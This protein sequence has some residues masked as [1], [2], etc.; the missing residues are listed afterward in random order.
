MAMRFSCF[1]HRQIYCPVQ[2][3]AVRK[4]SKP[5]CVSLTAHVG[6]GGVETRVQMP[7]ERR[8]G[9][10]NPPLYN[11][12]YI[13]SLSS[14]YGE[15]RH[16]ERASELVKQVK[17]A[18]NEEI[19]TV[20]KLELIDDLQRLGVSYLMEDEI[21]RI[22]DRLYAERFCKDEEKRSLY[23]TALEFRLFRQHGF[24]VGQ[25]VFDCFKNEMGDFNPS[26]GN[27]TLGLLQLYEASFLLRP[28]EWK[29]EEAT[30]FSKGLLEEKLDDGSL[31]VDENRVISVRSALELPI[32]W[33]IQWPNARWFIDAYGRRLDMNPVLLELAKTNFNILQAKH[34]Q[35]LKHVSMWWK[36]TELA[37]VLPFAR[38]RL[39]ECYFWT[40]GGLF[41]PEYG[42][43]RMQITKVNTLIT[44]ID[45]IFDV[46]GTLE[47]L[48]LFDEAFERG[49]V[50]AIE[51]LPHYMKMCHL[52]LNS[53]IDE[54]A[55]GV[56]KEQRLLVIEHLRKSW[57]DLSRSYLQEA[58]WFSAG[59]TPTLEEYIANAW[60]SI[61]AI[62]ILTNIYF[63][64]GD[65][66]EKEA[67]E[68]VCKYHNLVR[69]SGMLLRLANDMGTSP[70]EMAR[71]DVPKSIECYMNERGA[72]RE[73][74]KEHIMAMIAETWKHM[75]EEVAR[76][77]QGDSP[78]FPRAFVRC[79]MDL[80]RMAQYMYQHGDG[81]GTQKQPQIK[82]R[83][84]SLL[85]NPIDQ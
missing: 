8:S 68:E 82:N 48:K 75:N 83:I 61:S 65:P 23:S 21:H 66:I 7:A 5:I 52:V 32:H 45:D 35:E 22:L 67:M 77:Q 56:L 63:T 58:E 20:Q 59:H 73:E 40:L 37:E 33:R 34:Q 15:N 25:D 44:V 17:M 53:L 41:R 57:R 28:G 43:T 3:Y 10:Y 13:Q 64:T 76:T 69:F 85:F 62:T 30:R 6:V 74:A 79:A 19:D 12:D 38:D 24:I 39:V 11:F 26:L 14:E 27:D 46:Y 42:Y 60:M 4:A 70:D 16:L 78:Q 80:G 72:S 47:E 29:L 9:N 84:P 49:D 18:L 1:L 2:A 31:G 71:G 51:K 55:Y 81:H 36:Q 50:K 54:I